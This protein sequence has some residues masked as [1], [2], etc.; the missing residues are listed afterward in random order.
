[1]PGSGLRSGG[2]AN[3]YWEGMP[4]VRAIVL[5]MGNVLVSFDFRRAYARLEPL[6]PRPI[7]EF[8]TD[9]RASG[10]VKLL[11]TGRMEPADFVARF[12]ALLGAPMSYGD[13]CS[14]W[15]SIFLPDPLIPDPLLA[16][17]AS[18]YP[19]VLLSNTNAIHFEMIERNYGFLRHFSH[20]V[21]S[22]EAGAAKPSPEIYRLA[23]ARAGC[24]P[25]ECFFA[26]DI[27]EFVEG[28]RREGMD[29]VRFESA[30]SL[31]ADLRAR[32]VVW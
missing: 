7:A 10:I 11:E 30:A 22:H 6:S 13:F 27:P 28:A 25:G 2:R 4:S 19:M 14:I 15:S 24:E 21:L 9:L 8:L 20:R 31:E 17:L 18:R 29:A 3:T 23:I 12:Q 16:S 5:D 32:G 26:D 1:M